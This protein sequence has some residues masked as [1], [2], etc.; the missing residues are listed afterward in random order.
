MDRDKKCS[1]VESKEQSRRE[2]C[3]EERVVRLDGVGWDRK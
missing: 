2:E 3:G 1:G